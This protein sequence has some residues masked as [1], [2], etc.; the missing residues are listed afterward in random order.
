MTLVPIRWPRAGVLVVALALAGC[1]GGASPSPSASAPTASTAPGSPAATQQSGAASPTSAAAA[2]PTAAPAPWTA[3]DTATVTMKTAKGTI[4]MKVDGGV[5]PYA[6][7]N[8][9]GLVGC[10]YYDGV[11]FHR[12]VPGF[13]IQGGDG[14]F[15]REPNLDPSR[16]GEGG[17]GY[18]IPDDGVFT[19]YPRGTVAMART[20]DPH[21]EGS[22][23]FIVLDDGANQALASAGTYAIIGH[24]TSGMDAVDAIAAM[25]NSG[26]PDNA[27]LQPVPIDSATVSRP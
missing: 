20:P 27:A 9:V 2:C 4:V 25:P 5:A 6:T 1:S 12:L 8:F 7:A 19:S 3:A 18:T 24:V 17:P 22:Q 23:F 10:G 11:I 13:V 21:S 15:G 16:V 14:Q 26:Q